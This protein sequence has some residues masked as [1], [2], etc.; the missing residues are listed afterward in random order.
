M[1]AYQ[2]SNQTNFKGNFFSMTFFLTPTNSFPFVYSIHRFFDE[3]ELCLMCRCLHHYID[4]PVFIILKMFEC[5]GTS[6]HHRVWK[7]KKE[8][9]RIFKK[10]KPN[11]EYSKTPRKAEFW[12]KSNIF[13]VGSSNDAKSGVSFGVCENQDSLFSTV[14][15]QKLKSVKRY[16]L[17]VC[18]AVIIATTT[19]YEHTLMKLTQMVELRLIVSKFSQFRKLY[20]IIIWDKPDCI[21]ESM[22]KTT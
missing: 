15:F 8:K 12:T 14:E 3:M 16:D 2:N 11:T 17:V 1:S 22:D 20:C 5:G 4:V 21:V 6:I 7:K 19:K 18:Q 13:W 10:G 9:H